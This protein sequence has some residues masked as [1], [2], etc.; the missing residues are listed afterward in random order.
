MASPNQFSFISHCSH[1][2]IIHISSA[3]GLRSN[4]R[5]TTQ[6]RILVVRLDH[7][8]CLLVVYLCRFLNS[9]RRTQIDRRLCIRLFASWSWGTL[10]PRS[11]Y[12][13]R[14]LQ[15][16][17]KDCRSVFA[18]WVRVICSIYV[19]TVF[20]HLFCARFSSE[21]MVQVSVL[22]SVVSFSLSVFSWD[23]YPMCEELVI[24]H[25]C[26][27]TAPFRS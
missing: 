8:V 22:F 5:P 20:S 11:W 13:Q 26:T 2:P 14:L 25:V 24:L 4:W 3:L 23:F 21:Q 15:G 6:C 1:T 12:R 17:R 19:S 16:T 7:V 18:W 27:R 10:S 9:R